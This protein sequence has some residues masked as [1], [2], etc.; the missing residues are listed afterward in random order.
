MQA[1][2]LEL[3]KLAKDLSDAG[4][5]S[6]KDVAVDLVQDSAYQI[7]TLAKSYAPVR[8]GA[9]RQSIHV[10]FADD[11]LAA[12]VSTGVDYAVFQE[13]GT[14][15]RGE[16]GASIPTA[17]RG[18]RKGRVISR[19]TGIAPRPYMRPATERV[20]TSLGDSLGNAAIAVIVKGP[21]APET[22]NNAPATGAQT[23]PRQAVN[24]ASGLLEAGKL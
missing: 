12:E 4:A 9:L 24:V 13:F 20:A 6:F 17:P 3:Q 18:A 21:N 22:R 8:T 10:T 1:A 16:F 14:G 11:G 5:G 7:E 2:T 19:P 23:T 15:S